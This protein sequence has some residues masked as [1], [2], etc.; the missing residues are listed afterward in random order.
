M[1]W[2]KPNVKKRF[3][4]TPIGRISSADIK[5]RIR[6]ALKTF[7]GLGRGLRLARI[8]LV[9]FN[10]SNSGCIAFIFMEPAFLV[11]RRWKI[12]NCSQLIFSPKENLIRNLNK[13]FLSHLIIRHC[14]FILY[15]L[16]KVPL[17]MVPVKD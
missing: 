6:L 14:S 13:H 11:T 1:C 12:C 8:P 17:H 9:A 7:G 16:K 15:A 4:S 10:K 3:H 5:R 2:A